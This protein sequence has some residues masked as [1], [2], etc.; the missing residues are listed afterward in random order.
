MTVLNWIGGHSSNFKDALNWSPQQAP[1]ST[2]D[3]VIAPAALTSITTT[4]DV[5]NSLTD[6][7]NTTLT[8]AGTSAFTIKDAP[9]AANPSGTSV[10]RGTL[11]LQSAADLTFYGTFQN[12]GLFAAQANSDLWAFGNLSNTG[13]MLMAAD[14]HVGNAATAGTVVNAAGARYAIT[15]AA[16]IRAGAAGSSFTNNGSVTHTGTGTSDVTAAFVNDGGVT[17]GSG[18]MSFLGGLT[19]AGVITEH[20][21]QLAIAHAITGTG[22]IDLLGGTVQLGAGADAH[23]T[24]DFLTG[25]ALLK[26]VGAGSF[27]GT[28]ADFG[29]GDKIDLLNT[30]ATSLHFS[31]GVLSVDNGSVGVA[32]LH[33]SGSYTNSNFALS[34]D[35]HGGSMIS[36]V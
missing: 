20:S 22:K 18:G 25:S 16:D 8:I 2:S 4:D 32:H 26:L 35:G 5:I 6:N 33:F 30:A 9:D 36:F 1:G 23:Q 24:V 17:V 19:N 31:G 28:I 15:G 34:S 14:L 21:A 12:S 13:R 7:A 11:N 3:V 10:N 29:T 27:A